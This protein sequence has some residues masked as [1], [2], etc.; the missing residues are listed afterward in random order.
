MV[1]ADFTLSIADVLA[2]GGVMLTAMGGVW[3]VKRALGLIG[4]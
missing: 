3:V 4:R 2:V 1:P